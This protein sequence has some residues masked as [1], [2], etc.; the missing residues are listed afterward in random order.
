MYLTKILENVYKLYTQKPSNSTFDWNSTIQKPS[1]LGVT[2]FLGCIYVSYA[3]LTR[4]LQKLYSKIILM[5]YNGAQYNV[6]NVL[7]NTPIPKTQK[8]NFLKY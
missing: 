4:F 1:N 8:K 3:T 6:G 7:T 2:R 5:G